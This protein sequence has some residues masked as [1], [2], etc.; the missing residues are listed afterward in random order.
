MATKKPAKKPVEKKEADFNWT[1]AA[2]LPAKLNDTFTKAMVDFDRQQQETDEVYLRRWTEQY[3]WITSVCVRLKLEP[4]P[5][6]ANIKKLIPD[7][8]RKDELPL[9]YP[10]DMD[11]A[12]IT[13]LPTSPGVNTNEVLKSWAGIRKYLVKNDISIAV[14]D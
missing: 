11:Y 13:F 10:E 9:I 4:K 12:L 14:L 2:K 3:V 8:F 1:G 5:L 7:R 6:I